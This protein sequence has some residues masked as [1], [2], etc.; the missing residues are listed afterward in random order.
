MTHAR[1]SLFLYS[2]KP[3]VNIGLK[4]LKSSKKNYIIQIV[5]MKPKSLGAFLFQGRFFLHRGQNLFFEMLFPMF[6]GDISSEVGFP[7]GKLVRLLACF[8]SKK[9]TLTNSTQK[10]QIMQKKHTLTQNHAMKGNGHHKRKSIQGRWVTVR[11]NLNI[12]STVK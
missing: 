4:I 3:L 8:E 1:A 2:C 12:E 10:H 9:K 11:S 7:V 6:Q 5:P